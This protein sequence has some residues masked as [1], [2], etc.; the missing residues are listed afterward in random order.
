MAKFEKQTHTL[1]EEDGAKKPPAH[2]HSQIP[3]PYSGAPDLFEALG[4]A[5]VRR[6]LDLFALHR[7]SDSRL[8]DCVRRGAEGNILVFLSSCMLDSTHPL[9]SLSTVISST[10]VGEVTMAIEQQGLNTRVV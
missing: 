1:N 9:L 10:S 7:D 2:S 4:R 5:D 6:A 3:P 8:F